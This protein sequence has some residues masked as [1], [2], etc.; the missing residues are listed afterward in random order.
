MAKDITIRVNGQNA[1][2]SLNVSSVDGGNPFGG[3]TSTSMT[4]YNPGAVSAQ[5]YRA[6]INGVDVYFASEADFLKADRALRDMMSQQG[7]PSVGGAPTLGGRSGGWL[8]TGAETASAVGSFLQGRNIRRKLG[9]FDDALAKE[10]AALSELDAMERSGKYNDL[11]PVIRRALEAERYAT[12]SSLSV[13]E[14]QLTAVDIQT[15][16]G[17]VK[18]ADELVGSSTGIGASGLGTA[19][20]VGLGGIAVGSLFS[21]EERRRRRSRR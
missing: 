7:G 6:N 9:D 15:G 17:V 21:S 5:G 4:Q 18:V 13:L 10:D 11:I 3:N 14:D 20:A 19:A 12:E 1:D 16:A 8:R 2:G